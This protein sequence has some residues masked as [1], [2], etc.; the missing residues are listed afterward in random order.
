MTER[1]TLIFLCERGLV[2]QDKWSDRDS[3]GAQ[4][5][6][7]KA[8]VLL[9][10]GCDYRL[11]DSPPQTEDTIWIDVTYEGFDWFEVHEMTTDLFYI[12]TESRLERTAGRD[13]Y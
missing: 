7:G 11:A 12:P 6:L 3:A 13:W 8:W 5:Q 4:L 2:P 10:A 9:R 1:D